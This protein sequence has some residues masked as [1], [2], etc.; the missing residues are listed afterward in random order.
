MS[1]ELELPMLFSTTKNGTVM[2]WKTWCEDDVV[3][4]TYGYKHTGKF[5]DSIQTTSTP[6]NVGKVNETTAEEQAKLDCEAGWIKQLDKGYSVDGDD[7][8]AVEFLNR[9]LEAKEKNGGNNHG[10]MKSRSNVSEKKTKK[11]A[12]IFLPMLAGKYEDEMK[13]RKGKRRVRTFEYSAGSCAQPKLDGVRCVARIV[14]GEVQ[15]LSR[16]GKQIV[17]LDHI[18]EDIT[19]LLKRNEDIILDGEVYCHEPDLENSSANARFELITGA[20]RSVRKEA[21]PDEAQMQY[22]VFDMVDLKKTW[23]ER[24]R[25]LKELFKGKEF[26]SLRLVETRKVSCEQEMQECMK[27]WV[28]E[29]YEGIILRDENLMYTPKLRSRLLLKHKLFEDCEYEVVDIEK[30][31]G[32]TEDG[33]AI[34]CL[35]T[36]TG[37]L[38]TCRPTGT[39]ES[40]RRMFKKKHK[41]IGQLVNVKHQ[42]RGLDGTPRF[43]TS[44]GVIRNYE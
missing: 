3:H 32:G 4:K 21:H 24:R 43:P 44:D 5:R 15:L 12:A 22:W 25:A 18:R 10:I 26:D 37:A 40:R 28:G 23:A 1:T 33:A 36:E 27:E 6:K 29:G 39:I 8:D 38:F 19:K 11:T 35:K 42:G 9:V 20:A 41:W 7:E 34:F 13:P 30:S 14:D 31:V 2:Q 17:F 16:K